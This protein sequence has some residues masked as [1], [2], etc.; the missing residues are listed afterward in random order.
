MVADAK[1]NTRAAGRMARF[2][3]E[4]PDWFDGLVKLHRVYVDADGYSQCGTYISKRSVPTW[5]CGLAKVDGTRRYLAIDWLLRAPDRTEAMRLVR[6]RL[7]R[8][9]FYLGTDDEPYNINSK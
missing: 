2:D 7:P 6:I 9:R 3:I 8:C 5:W 1:H 4:G